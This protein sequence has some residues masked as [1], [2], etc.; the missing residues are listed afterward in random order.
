MVDAAFNIF[1]HKKMER[2]EEQTC[3]QR[4]IITKISDKRNAGKML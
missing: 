2:N 3:A 1:N 4:S